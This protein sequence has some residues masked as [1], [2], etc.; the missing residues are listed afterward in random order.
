MEW[1]VTLVP[2]YHVPT[3]QLHNIICVP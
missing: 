2:T 3:W 1:F